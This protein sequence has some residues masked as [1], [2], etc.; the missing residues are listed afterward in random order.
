MI[1]SGMR[2]CITVVEQLSPRAMASR[3]QGS[4]SGKHSF[5]SLDAFAYTSNVN[6]DSTLRQEATA[7][8]VPVAK[9]GAST[10]VGASGRRRSLKGGSQS[11]ETAASNAQLSLSEG[12]EQSEPQVTT[13]GAS[14]SYSSLLESPTRGTGGAEA[15]PSAKRKRARKSIPLVYEGEGAGVDGG[16]GEGAGGHRQQQEQ[17]QESSGA[18]SATL[19][20]PTRP[21]KRKSATPSSAS[22]QPAESYPFVM[23]P[24]SPARGY[25]API[26]PHPAW[27]LHLSN[28]K[29]MRAKGGAA[30]E[31]AVD[32]MG[33]ERCVDP[34][35]EPVVQRFQT[36][37]GLLLSSQTRDEV[38]YACVQRL[39]AH[40]ALGKCS[41]QAIAAAPLETL[42]AV[43][44][45]PPAVGFWRN[46]AKFLQGTAAACVS[47]HGGDI[48]R[49]LQGLCALPGIGP[50][51]AFIT[52]NVAWGPRDAQGVPLPVES[53]G[54]GAGSGSGSGDVEECQG[55][56]VDTHVHRIVNR[57]GWVNTSQPEATRVHLQSWLPRQ[58]WRA[59]NVLL[60]G[61]GQ[62]VCTPIGPKC[63]VCT[64]RDVCPV[65]QGVKS[66]QVKK[67]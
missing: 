30:S 16:E 26:T 40:P 9:L 61:F 19:S 34:G 66:P 21:T 2:H 37:V 31:A 41:P 50:K 65:A 6:P 25:G 11:A 46:K 20:T 1:S 13:A 48:P 14:S 52:L 5:S 35:A 54:A 43:L 63:G 3:K 23:P 56:G 15:P 22:S 29:G 10:V 49:S 47:D 32:R 28:I 57:L 36:L 64:N 58:E 8:A 42:E 67:L 7:P 24:G 59:L 33:C 38:T 62:S 53:T 39:I 44:L 45:G 51:M 55:I 18:P 12:H 27:A 4:A 17:E 60:V